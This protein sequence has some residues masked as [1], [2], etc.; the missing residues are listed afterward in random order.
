MLLTV[1]N[2]VSNHFRDRTGYSDI[3]QKN[4]LS[5]FIL[6]LIVSIKDARIT[7]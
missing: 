7:Q 2:F 1:L 3:L 4:V 6:R 5:Y